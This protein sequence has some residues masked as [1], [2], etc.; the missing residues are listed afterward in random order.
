MMD[1]Y[2]YDLRLNNPITTAI[3]ITITA[4]T[5]NM[6][7]FM[8]ALKIPAT[9]SHELHKVRSINVRGS[10]KI[11]IFFILFFLRVINF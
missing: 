11:D 4:I 10:A 1:L 9:A 6:P 5:M 8:P 2:I 7:T 3:M